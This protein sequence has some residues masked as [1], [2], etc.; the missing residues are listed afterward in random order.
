MTKIIARLSTALV[1]KNVVQVLQAME[2]KLQFYQQ[3]QAELKHFREL[4]QRGDFI[5]VP[6]ETVLKPGMDHANVAVL[7]EKLRSMGLWQQAPGQ[8]VEEQHFDASLKESVMHFQTRHS[9]DADGIVGRN[10]F[11][12]L[13]KSYADR[14]DQVRINLDRDV[15][16]SD[17]AGA[18]TFD[19]F[20]LEVRS[21]IYDLVRVSR[22][23]VNSE[24][25]FCYFEYNGYMLLYPQYE[26]RRIDYSDSKIYRLIDR[27]SGS[28]FRFAVRSCAFA[29]G[30]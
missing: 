30:I 16:I 9:L 22:E 28:E 14:I 4:E 6:D 25:Q 12:E 10:S 7:R 15:E 29:P 8:V 13:N 20:G 2:P 18:R 27:A 19:D 5:A 1:E 23:I 11:Q 24:S 17:E 3:L 21:P 26:I